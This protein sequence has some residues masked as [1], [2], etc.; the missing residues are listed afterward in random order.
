MKKNNVR[1]N[2]IY[3][4]MYQ[5]VA[6]IIPII[7]T[8]YVSRV[9][10]AN[11]IGIYGYTVSISAYFILFGSLGISLYGQREI[12]YCQGDSKKYSKSFYEILLLRFIAMTISAI[13][14]YFIFVFKSN[15]YSIY[16]KI[17]LVEIIANMF[18]I[19]WFLQGLEEFKKTVVRNII[20]RIIS[21]VVIFL[22]VKSKSDLPIYFIIYVLSILIGNLSLW[23]YLPKYLKK[24]KIKELNMTKHLKPALVLFVPQ[25]AIQV[26]TVLDRTM[27][28]ILIPAKEEVGFYT[29]GEHILKLLLTIITSLGTVMLPRIASIFSTGDKEKIKEYLNKSFNFVYFLGMPMVFGII[30]VSRKFVPVF[31]GSGYDRVIY[32]MMT[33][34]PILIF[35]GLSNVLGVQYLLPTKRQK[36]FTISVFVGAIINFGIN[37]ILIPKYGA[38]G[39][40]IGTIIA[41]L[42]VTIVQ[43]F[44]VRKDLNVLKIL[45]ISI[46]Y[47]IGSITM[48]V[49]L[50]FVRK[51]PLSNLES[52]LLQVSV[53]IVVYI[54]Y[55]I[56]TKNEFVFEYYNQ[57]KGIIK[58][59]SKLRRRSL[60]IRS[61]VLF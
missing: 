27:I 48:F 39:A 19:S 22:F 55:L 23:L 30:S 6:I 35:I 42:F 40:A 18:D 54:L 13:L 45:K 34:S 28:G 1:K 17:L 41:E 7:T 11:N 16:F 32:V 24:I 50:L 5:I 46:T 15:D 31:F 10:G 33:I 29:Q 8:P 12:A 60:T 9:L 25:I 57:F 59:K 52:V 49:A 51:I 4:V 44:Y 43:L 20:V 21:L 61:Q 53:G 47:F 38:I 58:S 14:F 56:I 3:N 36:E 2:Y 37:L 26:Y